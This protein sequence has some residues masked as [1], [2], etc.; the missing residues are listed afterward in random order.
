M[1]FYSP[2]PLI[3]IIIAVYNDWTALNRCLDSITHQIDPPDLEVIVVDDG[4]D[5]VGPATICQW[6]S[7]LPLSISR[8]PH[9]GISRARNRGIRDARGSI[10]F[11]VDA[12]SRLQPN[13]LSALESAIEASPAQSYFQ[14][15][16]AGEGLGVAGRAEN[17][18]LIALQNHLLRSNGCIRY[19]NTAGFAVRRSKVDVEKGLFDPAA[20]RAEDTLLLAHLIQRQELPFFVAEAIVGHDVPLSLLQCLRKDIRSALLERKTFEMIAA[21]GIT[22]RMTHRERLRMLW[23]MWGLSKEPSIGRRAWFVLAARQSLQRIIS[24]VYPLFRQRYESRTRAFLLA[25][26]DQP[27]HK[28]EAS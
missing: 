26:T 24:F 2:M 15:R 28:G 5:E 19:L 7:R 4:S 3:S 8:Q 23:A 14:A 1:R 11:F 18:R 9:T 13:T 22:I 17:L 16:L 25:R 21:M 20:L 27:T 10:L 6:A 12:D